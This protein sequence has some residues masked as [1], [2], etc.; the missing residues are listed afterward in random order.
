MKNELVFETDASQKVD[1]KFW[2]PFWHP[3]FFDGT[4]PCCGFKE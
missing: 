1:Y 3:Y 2:Q 4:D